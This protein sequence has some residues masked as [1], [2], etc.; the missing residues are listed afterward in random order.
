MAGGQAMLCSTIDQGGGGRIGGTDLR[1]DFPELIWGHAKHG[2]GDSMLRCTFPD[3]LDGP[4]FQG[5]EIVSCSPLCLGAGEPRHVAVA[6]AVLI[7]DDPVSAF[8]FPK[9]DP[10][11]Q[12]IDDCSVLEAVAVRDALQFGGVG[13]RNGHENA[14]F[15]RREHYRTLSHR[16]P[17]AR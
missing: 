6:I 5:T 12:I 14:P 3:C 7:S 4:S 10:S 17:G 16:R 13:R 1:T 2:S 11:V 15:N 9:S 8:V